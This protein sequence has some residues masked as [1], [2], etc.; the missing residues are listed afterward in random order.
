MREGRSITLARDEYRR[1]PTELFSIAIPAY[2]E[3]Y[4]GNL[5]RLL[6][7]IARQTVAPSRVQVVVMVNNSIKAA[8]DDDS[9]FIENKRTVE[10]L[11]QIRSALPYRLEVIDET[12]GIDRVMGTLRNRA[13]DRATAVTN[14]DARRHVMINLD[15]DVRIASDYLER[16]DAYYAHFDVDAVI[17]RRGHTLPATVDPLH[18]QMMGVS[19]FGHINHDMENVADFPHR[20]YVTPQI[21]ARASVVREL[22]GFGYIDFEEDFDFG[23]RLG[24][25]TIVMAPDIYVAQSD[26]ARL[27]GFAAAKRARI[28][29]QALRNN[30]QVDRGLPKMASLTTFA[31]SALSPHFARLERQVED[32]RLSGFEALVRFETFAR[33]CFLRELN[34]PFP[35]G[36]VAPEDLVGHEAGSL[37]TVCDLS[38]SP[39]FT[40]LATLPQH[41][42][43]YDVGSYL[44]AAVSAGLQDAELRRFNDRVAF[45]RA[46]DQRLIKM[47]L[48]TIRLL[49]RGEP[50]GPARH[51]DIFDDHLRDQNSTL[52]Q[53]IEVQ[54]RRRRR[55]STKYDQP[56]TSED[57]LLETLIQRYPDFLDESLTDPWVVQNRSLR[58]LNDWFL[59]ARSR[60]ED[61]PGTSAFLLRRPVR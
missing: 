57:T 61:Y 21:T 55:E 22:G 40:K 46:F 44:I 47:R 24:A 18:F 33:Q 16:L 13:L 34:S 8:L 60:P 42:R 54:L 48:R 39:L 1:G 30:G 36:A 29:N 41:D 23:K 59:R 19:E 9:T 52:R 58:F 2:R 53:D 27:D 51:S 7:Q 6:S 32:R 5:K 35:L 20:G 56:V 38:A 14:V 50:L 26:R 31:S 37:R 17:T 4:N 10:W 25:H 45:R 28:I 49:M 11:Q 12:R 15:A 43:P 3:F